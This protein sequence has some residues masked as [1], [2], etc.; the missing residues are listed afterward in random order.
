VSTDLTYNGLSS[1]NPVTI[2]NEDNDVPGVS[3][4]VGGSGSA[5]T[6]EK[7]GGDPVLLII[8]LRTIPNAQVVPTHIIYLLIIS[9]MI[10]SCIHFFLLLIFPKI[11]EHSRGLAGAGP[12][13]H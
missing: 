12:R 3:V 5:K 11:G 9:C 1:P 7:T 4:V 2:V 8:T 6:Y 10:I 13:V